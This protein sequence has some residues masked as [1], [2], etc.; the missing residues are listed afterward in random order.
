MII[1][2]KGA[3]FKVTRPED[4]YWAIFILRKWKD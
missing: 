2:Y 3:S 4:I 1:T